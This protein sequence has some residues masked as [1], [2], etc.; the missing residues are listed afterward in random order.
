M[1]DFPLKVVYSRLIAAR[2]LR[3]TSNNDSATTTE[4]KT[5][6]PSGAVANRD[7]VAARV[8]NRRGLPQA[9]LHELNPLPASLLARRTEHLIQ[10]V[11]VG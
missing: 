2:V 8:I 3:Q 4:Q 10:C 1:S 7:K 5:T 9:Q 11:S 6:L